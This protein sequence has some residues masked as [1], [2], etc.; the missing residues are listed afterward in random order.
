MNFF[1]R[2]FFL[3]GATIVS[4]LAT[5]SVAQ[6]KSD[7]D[8]V[9]ERVEILI[10]ASS[11]HALESLFGH[12]SVLFIPKGKSWNE[13]W[14]FSFNANTT[15]HS[16]KEISYLVKGVSGTFPFHVV[17]I[18]ATAYFYTKLIEESRDIQRIP[19]PL[20]QKQKRQ[21]WDQMVDF[22]LHPEKLGKYNYRQKNCATRLLYLF[23]MAGIQIPYDQIVSSS[24]SMAPTQVPLFMKDSLITPFPEVRLVSIKTRLRELSKKY[25]ITLGSEFSAKKNEFAPFSLEQ[26]NKLKSMSVED[27][28]LAAQ[29]LN[30]LDGLRNKIIQEEIRSR[31]QIVRSRFINFIELPLSFYSICETSECLKSLTM[32]MKNYYSAVELRRLLGENYY[33]F[34]RTQ[35]LFLPEV[36]LSTS[37]NALFWKAILNEFNVRP[38]GSRAL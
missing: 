37:Q 27:L 31:K 21:L 15:G 1:L 10:T 38:M 8:L 24:T 29:S 13:G 9:P 2:S 26:I 11:T 6:E 35:R 19:V 7:N 3:A 34:L 36:N 23:K 20:T 22:S 14:V 18:P 5:K 28:V 25:E 30:F 12:A 33:T 32:T 17:P 4:F 16:E